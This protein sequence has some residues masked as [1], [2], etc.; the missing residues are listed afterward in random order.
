FPFHLP[1]PPGLAPDV[2][3]SPPY[4]LLLRGSRQVRA[5]LPPQISEPKPSV[6]VR[7]R[8]PGQDAPVSQRLVRVGVRDADDS[9]VSVVDLQISVRQDADSGQALRRMPLVV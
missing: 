8:S 6:V 3:A 1:T 9:Q 5:L 7:L 2:R 4:A